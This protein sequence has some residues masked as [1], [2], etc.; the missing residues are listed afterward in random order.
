MAKKSRPE[1]GGPAKIV[2]LWETL[3]AAPRKSPGAAF[4][5]A[6]RSAKRKIKE[7]GEFRG[8]FE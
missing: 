6:A 7:V 5:L 3:T 1:N 8:F 2:V 4:P